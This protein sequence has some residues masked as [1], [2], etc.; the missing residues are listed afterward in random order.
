MKEIIEW[1]LL[2]IFVTIP[3]L[4]TILTLVGAIVYIEHVCLL[5]ES[6]SMHK[7]V[8]CRSEEGLKKYKELIKGE[9]K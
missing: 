5:Q 6:E 1:I 2:T 9:L 4:F 7:E 3:F 8:Y